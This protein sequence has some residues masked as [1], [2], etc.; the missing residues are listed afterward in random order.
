MMS[1]KKAKA[2]RKALRQAERLAELLRR[3]PVSGGEDLP[4]V[5]VPKLSVR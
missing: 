2:K 4:P 1:G 3:G 5:G